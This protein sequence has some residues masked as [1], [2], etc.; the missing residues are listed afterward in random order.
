MS[1]R[2]SLSKLREQ[3]KQKTNKRLG[4]LPALG[5]VVLLF[6]LCYLKQLVHQFL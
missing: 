4:D 5:R 1:R 6:R 2:R 3:N